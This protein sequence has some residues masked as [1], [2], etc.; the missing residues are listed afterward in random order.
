M[1][2]I[3]YP[4]KQD[5]PRKGALSLDGER[6]VPGNNEVS[7]AITLHRYWTKLVELGAV[8]VVKAADPAEPQP[9]QNDI[10]ISDLTIEEAEPVIEAETD[11]VLLKAWLESDS[12]AGI[13]TLI[14][15][16][17]KSLEA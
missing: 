12:R 4:E 6:L 1:R 13:K 17:I 10:R 3:F 5:P 11:I 15:R 2:V 8:K 16:Q 14:S 7:E 9:K